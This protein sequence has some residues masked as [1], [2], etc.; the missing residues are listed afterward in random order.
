K[1]DV[2]YYEI[3]KADGSNKTYIFFSEMLNDFDREDLIK[4]YRLLNEKYAS[5][6]PG[7]DDLMLSGDLKIMFEPD[8]DD[9]VWKNHQH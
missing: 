3:H 1:G 8:S 6:R 7:F 4:L 2:R 9:E 5:T